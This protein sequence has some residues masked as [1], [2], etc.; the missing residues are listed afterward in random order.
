MRQHRYYSEAI[1]K[2]YLRAS[3]MYDNHLLIAI[4][5]VGLFQHRYRLVKHPLHLQG[6]YHCFGGPIELAKVEMKMGGHLEIKAIQ[7]E[8][9]ICIFIVNL[10]GRYE[11][12]SLEEAPGFA[13]ATEADKE[14]MTSMGDSHPG[15]ATS[16]G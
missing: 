9:H 13:S 8:G 15:M 1:R 3:T 16:V 7:F 12:I 6:G 4:Q 2:S 11:V 5:R 14:S 10:D